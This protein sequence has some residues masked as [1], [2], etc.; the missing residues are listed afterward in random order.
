MTSFFQSNMFLVFFIYGLCFFGMGAV[1]LAMTRRRGKDEFTKHLYLLALF[2]LLHGTME[3]LDMYK[4]VAGIRFSPVFMIVYSLFQ[5]ALNIA[6]FTFLIAFGTVIS[7]IKLRKLPLI[8]LGIWV[9]V[10]IGG[11]IGFGTYD[12]WLPFADTN[13]RYLLALVGSV[14]T[15]IGFF[16]TSKEYKGKYNSSVLTGLK[17]TGVAFACYGFFGGIIVQKGD[18][19][20]AGILN[21][22]NFQMALG[23]IPVQAF[24]ALTAVLSMFAI[25][26]V[27]DVFEFG[28]QK[29]YEE[30]EKTEKALTS[31]IKDVNLNTKGLVNT[32][33][34]FS[35]SIEEST[36]S[37]REISST[38]SAIVTNTNDQNEQVEGIA[39]EMQDVTHNVSEIAKDTQKVA[40]IWSGTSEIAQSGS[41]SI[42]SA[43]EQMLSIETTASKLAETITSLGNLSDEINQFVD[44]I[45]NISAQTNLLSLNASIEAA[46]AG[47]AGKGFAVVAN[48]VRKLAEE[49]S[50]ATERIT[51]LVQQIQEKTA[52]ASLVTQQEVNAVNTGK[53]LFHEADSSFSRI[54]EAFSTANNEINNICEKSQSVSAATILMFQSIKQVIEMAEHNANTISNLSGRQIDFVNEVGNLTSKVSSMAVDLK[55]STQFEK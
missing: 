2:G 1:I 7:Q 19:L 4:N 52:S 46:R 39:A 53:Q 44:V 40:E 13:A 11:I 31:L 45:R 54:S 36:A 3:W 23:G 27:L 47:E 24:R 8:M 6:S 29:T 28:I 15:C 42:K 48:E 37:A 50:G 20:L 41:K 35:L 33:E 12:K 55:N 30:K 17:V 5:L 21:Y 49:A 43:V 51:N 10:F 25:L 14:L 34:N 22:P 16:K 32:L 38:V 18:Y 26:K 9:I